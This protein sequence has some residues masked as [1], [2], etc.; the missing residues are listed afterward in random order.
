PSIA[1]SLTSKCVRINLTGWKYEPFTGAASP[2]RLNSLA[3]YSAAFSPPG[4]PVP[5]PSNSA[6]ARMERCALA[7]SGVISAAYFCCT[8]SWA[9]MHPQKDGMRNSDNNCFMVLFLRCETSDIRQ[10]TTDTR[11]QT[12]EFS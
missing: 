8:G 9:I 1:N 3:M 5:R 10:W 11:Q 6:D 7:V 12:L 2:S 4:S